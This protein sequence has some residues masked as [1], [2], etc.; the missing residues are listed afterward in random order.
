M[1]LTQVEKTGDIFL[2]VRGDSGPRWGGTALLELGSS[3][4]FEVLSPSPRK[5]SD[6]KR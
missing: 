3:L 5:G 6:G 4:S 1:E 2:T